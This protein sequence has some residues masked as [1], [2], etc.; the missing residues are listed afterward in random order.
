MNLDSLLFTDL[1]LNIVGIL[2]CFLSISALNGI[3]YFTA[4]LSANKATWALGSHTVPKL[5][6]LDLKE[7]RYCFKVYYTL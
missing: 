5:N 7:C 2:L 6:F 4:L 3:E 1:T